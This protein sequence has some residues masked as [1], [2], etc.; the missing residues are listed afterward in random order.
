MKRTFQIVAALAALAVVAYGVRYYMQQQR[1]KKAGILS[2]NIVHQGE[3]WNVDFSARL[4]ANEKDIFNAIQHVEDSA[5]YSSA[6]KEVKIISQE[7]NKKTV[8]MQLAGPAGQSMP[9]ELQFEYFPE[10][11]KITYDTVNNPML[12]THAEYVL[13][14]EGTTTRIDFHQTTKMLM[15]LPVPDAMVK[16]ILRGIFIGQLEGIKKSL[17]ITTA[18]NDSEEDAAD[19]P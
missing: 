2:E 8:E 3:N 13:D 7:G 17:N 11:R 1:A 6:V 15:Q 14:D 12:T 19:E 5:K 4:P 18:E 10:N 16:D 9:N